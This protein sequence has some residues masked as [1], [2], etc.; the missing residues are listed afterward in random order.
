VPLAGFQDGD[1]RLAIRV[2][3]MLSGQ[4]V[5]RDVHFTVGS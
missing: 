2:T 1:Y 4:F 5:L 3:D